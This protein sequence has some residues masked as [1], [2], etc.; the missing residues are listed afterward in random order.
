MVR[1]RAGRVDENA[2]ARLPAGNLVSAATTARSMAE[3][4]EIDEHGYYDRDQIESLDGLVRIDN[5]CVDDGGHR[6][7]NEAQNDQ[8][9][10]MV[11]SLEKIREEEQQY[12]G[13]ARKR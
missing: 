13:H 8:Q 5:P 1:I 7:E 12:D 11:G 9:Q 4:A 6:Q 3:Q 2:G 10:R